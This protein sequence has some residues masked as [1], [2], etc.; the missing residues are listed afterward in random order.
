MKKLP[1]EHAMLGEKGMQKK[2]KYTKSYCNKWLSPL[3]YDQKWWLFSRM[4]APVDAAC[5][6]GYVPPAP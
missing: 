4:E 1:W 3:L 2:R 5:G 6:P